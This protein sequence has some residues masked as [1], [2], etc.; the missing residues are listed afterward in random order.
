MLHKLTT[1]YSIYLKELI[2]IYNEIG[3][4]IRVTCE[5]TVKNRKRDFVPSPLHRA[6]YNDSYGRLRI[7]LI[8]MGNSKISI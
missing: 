7:S 6:L 4:F 8:Q 5:Q 3:L 2:K 1:Q